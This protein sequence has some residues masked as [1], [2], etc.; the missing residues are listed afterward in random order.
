MADADVD[1]APGDCGIAG[2]EL[3]IARGAGDIGIPTCGLSRV[4][5]R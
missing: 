5:R 1:S 2:G 4:R 3:D